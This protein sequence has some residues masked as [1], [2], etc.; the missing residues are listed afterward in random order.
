MEIPA[1]RSNTVRYAPWR[2]AKRNSVLSYKY[3][4][5]SAKRIAQSVDIRSKA[6]S[7]ERGEMEQ[8]A[9]SGAH[10]AS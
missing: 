3:A 6:H 8:R 10:G 1:S 5:Q 9:E 4:W 2:S 7:A